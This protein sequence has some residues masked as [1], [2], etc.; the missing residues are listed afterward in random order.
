MA[1]ASPGVIRLPGQKAAKHGVTALSEALG[2]QGKATEALTK[3]VE[4]VTSLSSKTQNNK[5][6]LAKANELLAAAGLP[7]VEE[8]EDLY[9][10]RDWLTYDWDN[11]EGP[12]SYGVIYDEHEEE[13]T[14]GYDD[15]SQKTNQQAEEE[16]FS[17]WEEAENNIG[18]SNDGGS[19]GGGFGKP[20]VLD[21]DGDGVEL[22]DLDDS[23]AFYDI[24]GDGYRERMGWAAADDGFLAYDKDGDGIISAHD[25]LSFVSYVEGA[26][27]DLEGLAHFDTNGNGRLD[28]G[29]AEWGKFRV[30]QDL[31]QDGESDP[32]E[33]R[34]L[35][36]AGIESIAL[37]SDGVERTVANNE[38]FGEGTYTHSDGERSFLDAALRHSAYGFR[39]DADGNVT[40]GSGG[41][42]VLHV[43]GPTTE[44]VRSLD[45]A[46]LGVA[47]IVGHD[48]VDHLTAAPEGSLLS[49]AGG[50]DVLTGGAGDDWLHGGEGADTLRGGAGNDVLF[51]DADDFADGDV[52]GGAGFDIA[53][54]VGY[55]AVT[56][57]LAAHGLEAV[58]GG[59]GDDSLSTSG[60][61][62]V[63]LLGEG[64][65]D[66][67]TG[68]DGDDMLAGG[69]GAD[70]LRGGAGD[71]VLIVDADD[72]AE[73]AVDGGAGFDTAFVE[74]DEAVTIDLA[75]HGLEAVFG[76][77][78]GDTL[79]GG[80]GDDLMF[81]GGGDDTLTGNAGDDVLVGGDG[82]DTLKGGAGD[83]VY[84]FGRGGGRD[85]LRDEHL[86]GGRARQA[87]A[88]DVLS[89][90]G[91][92]G[93]ADVMLR[94]V[95]GSLVIALKDADDPNAAFEDL[96]DRVTI[97]NWSN[98]YSQIEVLAFGDG[99][100]LDL[101]EVVSTYRVTA[102]GAA[103]DLIAA[104]NA[105]HGG[106][107]PEGGNAYLGG[108]ADDA[109]VGG[110][111]DDALTGNGGD[112]VLVGGEGNDT[113]KGG[114]GDDVY[115]FG[116]G[117]GSDTLRDEYLVR[118]RAR[119]AGARDALFLEGDIGIADVM[120]RIV[121][122][123]L[124]IALKD[125]DDPDAA[126]EDLADR[127]TIENWSNRYSQ[128]EILAFGDGSRL[129]LKE[130]VSTYRVTAGGAAV[131]LVAAMNAAHGGAL[132]EGGNAYLGGRGNDALT[133]GAG[134]DVLVGGAGADRLRGGDG[135]DTASYA[136]STAGVTVDLS[137]GRAWGGHAGGDTLY[138][139][140]DLIGSRY[141]DRLI[142]DD[143]ANRFEGG[144]G[145]DRIDGGAGRDRAS[146]AGS[147]AGV[148]IDLST[149]RASG[150]HARGDTL[151]G[152]EDLTGSDH[153]DRLTGDAGANR[154]EGRGGNDYLRGGTGADEIEGG[155]GRDVLVGDG[156]ADVLRG[157]DGDD[158][159]YIDAEDIANG[160]VDG[161]EGYD[162][163][164]LDNV[165]TGVTMDLALHGL[166]SIVGG[167]GDDVLSHSGMDGDISMHGGRGDDI[168]T[169]SGGHFDNLDG[170]SG[171]DILDGGAGSDTLR[172]GAGDDTYLFGRG[173]GYDRIDN[174]RESGS[175]DV[176]RFGAEID[177]DQLW[178]RMSGDDLIVQVVGTGDRVRV[179]DW[180]DGTGNRLD[181]ELDDG[182]RLAAADVAQLVTAMAQFT[183]PGDGATEYTEEQQ[184]TLD[185]LLA[186]HWQASG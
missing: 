128:I 101:K 102:G 130:V 133:G 109:L 67:L 36:E 43:A 29:D 17:A 77:G 120:L 79:T 12:E 173:G 80:G 161:G 184:R 118:G 16:Y 174:R 4:V 159:L 19:D 65:D 39:E 142:G 69:E 15:Q 125:P 59:G 13:Q 55:E 135:R 73:G 123:S 74:G 35:S 179:D 106:T 129:D 124:V 34:T 146:Y 8:I 154:L 151:S 28:P 58:I 53:L 160:E 85:T 91:D 33:L 177:A 90:E 156:G 63:A 5:S 40:V 100:R 42:A 32:G 92:I 87:G 50:D 178:F 105:A 121:D 152:I 86:V 112:D 30:W 72:F 66:T 97:E 148:T 122:G 144:A 107:L 88:R 98:G 47:G 7:E 145:G 104:M 23:T 183:M 75:A 18:G 132:P 162:H 76:G 127:V 71:D 108:A 167:W 82:D 114:A 81:G 186:A 89:L 31:D 171:D 140:E 131:D 138:R 164:I 78:G 64:G 182:R 48:T 52:D 157:G 175:D 137:T 1:L 168:L 181:F 134:D 22:V 176:V 185:P 180:Y 117:G 110:D 51:V 163:A 11:Y 54:V 26:R 49:G 95:D 20:I 2:L 3:A 10:L 119:Q 136:A 149:G 113:L 9:A 115:V 46:A 99:S 94:M 169:G 170:G 6:N 24:D 147:D 70:T 111:G 44:A 153:A 37:T 25:E 143:G 141:N 103:V 116:R 93:I 21:L 155:D 68:G 27:T 41:D 84:V 83:D 172:G 126:F 166:E 60:T 96:A 56:I 61:D 45:A 57:D 62:G 14:G 38:V 158:I 165:D 150:G 139:I